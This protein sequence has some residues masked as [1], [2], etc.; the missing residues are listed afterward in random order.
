MCMEMATSL[1]S[2]LIDLQ[3]PASPSRIQEYS[4][5]ASSRHP[6]GRG[7]SQ[8]EKKITQTNQSWLETPPFYTTDRD[9]SFI[10]GTAANMKPNASVRALL[11]STL[12]L[13]LF[14]G[15]SCLSSHFSNLS[16]AS[17]SRKPGLHVSLLLSQTWSSSLLL[18]C[19]PLR[20][21][22]GH[23]RSMKSRVGVHR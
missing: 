13:S 1:P 16:I 22:K 12:T 6:R 15:R 8:G 9:S 14:L 5:P 23:S 3:S 4:Q 7:H 20:R 21:Q 11:G 2:P 10:L 19:P 17:C 18:L